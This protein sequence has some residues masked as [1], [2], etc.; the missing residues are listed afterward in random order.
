MADDYLDNPAGRLHRV[1]SRMK[2]HRPNVHVRDA[3]TEVLGIS[4]PLLHDLVRAVGEV[5]EL[6]PEVERQVAALPGRHSKER[7]MQWRPKVDEAL[8]C[9]VFQRS[10]PPP[11]IGAVADI[12]G[13]RE[14][15]TL[16]F[17][18]ETLHI[19]QTELGLEGEALDH[20]RRLI[21]ELLEILV[22]DSELD[23]D[24][25]ELLIEN[26][27]EMLRACDSHD[28]R[29]SAAM[30]DAYNVT[31]GSLVNNVQVT[32]RHNSSP[33]TWAKVI[34]VLGAVSAL[35]GSSAAV[36]NAIENLS[37]AHPVLEVVVA[38]RQLPK[39]MVSPAMSTRQSDTPASVSDQPLGAGR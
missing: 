12:Y 19:A 14:L 37:P 18:S 10:S 39:A 32:C 13:D 34:T 15:T 7:L 16:E 33:A 1:L 23:T 20:V 36:I 28:R 31:I 11:T 25:R 9:L 17:C 29:G 2:A 6:P 8:N 27:R 26:V 3:L 21:S 24:L 22:A 30:R 35:L 4:T 5:V 38:P